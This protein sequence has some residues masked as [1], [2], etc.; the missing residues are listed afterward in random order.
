MK[1]TV[2]GAS[3]QIGSKV[4]ELLTAGGHEV[5]AA[6]RASGVDVLTEEGVR[7]ALDGADVLVDVVNSPSFADDPVMEFFTT[8]TTNVVAAAQDAGVAHYVVLSI[9]GTD[10]LPES[11]YLR[12]KVVQEKVVTESG[13]PYSIVR[14]T[15]FHEFAEAIIGSMTAATESGPQ[16]RV[17]DALIQPIAAAE[18]AEQ[19]TWVALSEPVGGFV[20]LGGPDYLSFADLARAVSPSDVDIVVDPAAGYFGTPL[21]QRSLVTDEAALRGTTKFVDWYAATT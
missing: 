13:L 18:V 4:V 20:D 5:V 8:S 21:Q 2:V 17:P 1:V 19:V 3:G 9:V 12:A 16:I 6:S 7:A 10:Q 11:G 15:Q 14:A